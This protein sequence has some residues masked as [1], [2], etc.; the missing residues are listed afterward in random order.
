LK[1]EQKKT[2]GN[3]RAPLFCIVRWLVHLTVDGQGVN[4]CRRAQWWPSRAR[5]GRD[6]G[7]A[8]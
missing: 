2:H 7:C 1:G 3:S 8:M 4:N 6:R 5:K